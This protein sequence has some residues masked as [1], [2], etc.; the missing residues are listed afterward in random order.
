MGIDPVTQF[1]LDSRLNVEETTPVR[2][3]GNWLIRT[4]LE[5]ITIIAHHRPSFIQL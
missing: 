1:I 2:E 4:L 3:L 5:L